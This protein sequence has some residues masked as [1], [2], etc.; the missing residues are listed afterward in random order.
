MAEKAL[1]DVHQARTARRNSIS[2]A[3]TTL[4]NSSAAI[5]NTSSTSCN[6]SLSSSAA[7]LSLSGI[8]HDKRFPASKP[9]P[10]SSEPQASKI[11]GLSVQSIMS[12]PAY[13]IA[14]SAATASPLFTSPIAEA[15]RSPTPVA[16][17][18]QTTMGP[19]QESP[20]LASPLRRQAQQLVEE[21]RRARKA[22]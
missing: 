14:E 7:H 8:E 21:S 11:G 15:L 20:D 6:G 13:P 16:Q 19:V 9:N 18:T 1:L 2:I 5:V 10:T 17:P 22:W 12:P 3:T 4:A